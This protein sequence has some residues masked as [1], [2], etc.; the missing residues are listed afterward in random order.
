VPLEA[1]T[2]SYRVTYE[3]HDRRRE[4]V[5]AFTPTPTAVITAMAGSGFG[6]E[7]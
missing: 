2:G 4:V 6:V 3:R 1:P 7:D 5:L